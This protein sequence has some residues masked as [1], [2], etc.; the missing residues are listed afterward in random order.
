MT[1]WELLHEISLFLQPKSK[2]KQQNNQSKMK[3]KNYTITM[4]SQ[5]W[6]IWPGFG[7]LRRRHCVEHNLVEQRKG[8]DE[9]TASEM[10]IEFVAAEIWISASSG[11][12]V[13]CVI[14]CREGVWCL[15]FGVCF[16]TSARENSDS[17]KLKKWFRLGTNL[18]RKGLEGFL[19]F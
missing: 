16:E 2:T 3:N 4:M 13:F 12:V 14:V 17:L 6:E 8:E 1:C 18:G 5:A 15:D 10:R 7:D 9:K 11:F 19:F